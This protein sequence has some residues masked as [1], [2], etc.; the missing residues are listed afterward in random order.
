MV[1]VASL[2]CS[3]FSHLYYDWVDYFVEFFVLCYDVVVVLDCGLVYV[4]VELFFLVL[5]GFIGGFG[6]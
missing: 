2:W 3:V 6:G 5:G 4:L 1:L